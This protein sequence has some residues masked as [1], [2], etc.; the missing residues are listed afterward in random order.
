LIEMLVVVAIM[1]ILATVGVPS[2]NSFVRDMR[3]ASTMSDLSTDLYFARSEAIKR[4]ARMLV[5]ARETAT[6]N[7]CSTAGTAAAWMNGWLVCF[8]AN[9]DGACDAGSS[10]D[11]NP[12]RTHAALQAPISLS[13][14]TTA[15]VFLSVGNA[16]AAA[17]F[18]MTG[19]VTTTRTASVAASGSV[20]VRKS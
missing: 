7:A 3:L 10:T 15:V 20:T 1:A 4:N 19:G 6:S 2:L 14:P 12:M 9:V 5:C 16:S 18:T 13:G 8:D 11:P 17:A